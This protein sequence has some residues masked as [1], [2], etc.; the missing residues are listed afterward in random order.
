MVIHSRPTLTCPLHPNF[1]FETWT[2]IFFHF[3]EIYRGIL[4]FFTGFTKSSPTSRTSPITTFVTVREVKFHEVT[5][6]DFIQFDEVKFVK[7]QKFMKFQKLH[8]LHESRKE[9][10]NS[11]EGFQSRRTRI[12]WR[13]LSASCMCVSLIQFLCS[14]STFQLIL[15]FSL[16]LPLKC[17]CCVK[18][19]KSY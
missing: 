9:S 17:V 5:N 10:D 15:L 12:F 11:L 1:V 4:I 3:H 6:Y 14:L 8:E 18:T 7:L 19:D 2:S 16:S 13:F